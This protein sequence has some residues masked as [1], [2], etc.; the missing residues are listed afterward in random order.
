[1]EKMFSKTRSFSSRSFE[2]ME[3]AAFDLKWRCK[4]IVRQKEAAMSW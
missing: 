3:I 1:M 4:W 2:E